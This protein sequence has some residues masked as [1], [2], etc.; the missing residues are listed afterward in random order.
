MMTSQK[1]YD[2]SKLNGIFEDNSTLIKIVVVTGCLG[3][4]GSYFT[5]NY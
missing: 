3:F 2:L 5:Q 4:M 1:D